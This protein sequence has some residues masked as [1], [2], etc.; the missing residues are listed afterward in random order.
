MLGFMAAMTAQGLGEG[1]DSG[2]YADPPPPQDN[3]AHSFITLRLSCRS[4]P[5]MLRVRKNRH[6][7]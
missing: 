2:H 6:S 4:F 3:H 7:L 5:T 1:N